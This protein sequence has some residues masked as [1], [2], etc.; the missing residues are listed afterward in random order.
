MYRRHLSKGKCTNE[1]RRRAKTALPKKWQ[2]TAF[3]QEITHVP[4]NVSQL[5]GMRELQFFFAAIKLVVEKNSSSS[6]YTVIRSKPSGVI[7]NIS[8]SC[9][10]KKYQKS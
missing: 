1:S 6:P 8:N 10:L 7:L 4:K 5:L 9:S 2:K 3:L